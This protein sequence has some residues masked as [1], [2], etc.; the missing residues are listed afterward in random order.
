MS[1]RLTRLALAHC[2]LALS[3]AAAA[4]TGGPPESET[5]DDEQM[6]ELFTTSATYLYEDDQ[7]LQA[8]DQ[9][10]KALEIEPENRAMRRLIGWVRLRLGTSEDLIIA[11]QF[12]RK[13]QKEGDDNGA[14]LL[15]LATALER[16]GVAHDEAS[17]AV[18]AG[19]RPPPEGVD[20]D[21]HARALAQKARE[22]WLEAVEIH[23]A[24]LDGGEGSTRAMNG[25]Q[26]LYALL[27]QYEKSLEWSDVLL[28]RSQEELD[29]WNRMLSATDMTET[30][31]KLFRTNAKAAMDL[32]RDTHLFAATLLR[33]LDRSRE[34]IAHLD[35]VLEIE[36]D[37]AQAYSQRA[38]LLIELGEF[39]R[40]KEDLDRFIGL[41]Q[42]PFDDPDL[43]R[44]FEW[45]AECELKL[46]G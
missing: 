28:A 29:T 42:A 20:K 44:A 33:R 11:E 24:G 34:A 43:R 7:L 37:L 18:S 2:A 19:E 9:A 14:T 6:L 23:E 32:R 40:A 30:E 21:K 1:L 12:F 26:R 27:G 39:A 3:F 16:L 45:I 38:Q 46:R 8:Q 15:G 25:L 41:S 17:R 4:C 35:Q 10:V 36:P 5:P 22:Q 31:E 13:L